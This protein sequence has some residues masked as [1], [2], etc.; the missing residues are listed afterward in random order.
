MLAS[1]LYPEGL[2]KN[3]PVIHLKVFPDRVELGA[4]VEEMDGDREH[5]GPLSGVCFVEP[6]G[7]IT[8]G[9]SQTHLDPGT[10]SHE[11]V[12]AAL[13]W[14]RLH[15]G[16]K[17]LVADGEWASPVEERL[18]HMVDRLVNQIGRRVGWN[19]KSS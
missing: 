13:A 14:L 11:C 15:G 2:R 1:R 19:A 9:L 4:W 17:G 10:V 3:C 16:V 18:A 12:H 8:I 6:E 5:V 7:R